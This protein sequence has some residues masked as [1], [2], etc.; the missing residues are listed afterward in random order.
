MAFKMN[1][2]WTQSTIG[3]AHDTRE[4]TRRGGGH[5]NAG[6]LTLSFSLAIGKQFLTR[7]CNG[8]D[9]TRVKLEIHGGDV[10]ILPAKSEEPGRK[11]S[12][13]TYG[14]DYRSF[15]D[16]GN[17]PWINAIPAFGATPTP[18][19]LTDRGILMTMPAEKDRRP[20]EPYNQYRPRLRHAYPST[21]NLPVAQQA[22]KELTEVLP[23][24]SGQLY[25]VMVPRE[26][27]EQFHTLLRFLKL[28]ALRE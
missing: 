15:F 1:R 12:L 27:D 22:V 9:Y 16:G 4:L 20:I 26:T 28:E 13:S 18:T 19:K 3:K 6:S 14:R 24:S 25:L 10:L 8:H 17:Y 7:F 2:D 5:G 21:P 23:P 11:F